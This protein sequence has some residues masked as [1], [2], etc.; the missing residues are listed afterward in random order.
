[1]RHRWDRLKVALWS[2]FDVGRYGDESFP[3]RSF[4]LPWTDGPAV[5]GIRELFETQTFIHMESVAAPLTFSPAE[6]NVKGWV[7]EF[8]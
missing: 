5:E 8:I 2:T 7:Y 1:M 4:T 3:A 6:R